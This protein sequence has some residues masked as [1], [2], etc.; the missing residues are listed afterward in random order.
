[1]RCLEGLAGRKQDNPHMRTAGLCD[2][3]MH[4]YYSDG[5]TSPEALV[6]HA[7]SLGLTAVALTDHDN[8]RGIPEAQVVADEL[9]IWLIPGVE[10]ASQWQGYGWSEWGYAVD[11]LG[12][13]VDRTLPEFQKLEGEMLA[14]YFDQF[15]EMV[16]EINRQGYPIMLEEI[17]Q[18]HPQ[19]PDV[20][21]VAS[22]LK[23]KGLTED[24]DTALWMAADCWNKICRLNFPVER[25]IR[26]IHAAGGVAVLAHP[27]VVLR[28]DG[29]WIE[30]EDLAKLVEMGLDG[31]EVYHYRLPDEKTRRHFLRLA[32]R[33]DLVV[34][35][36][37][38]EHGR[39][40]G[41][42]RM[43]TQPITE[44][45]ITALQARRRG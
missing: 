6:R 7:A 37:S 29:S 33:F 15:A 35:G 9:G 26:T 43:G 23:K 1:M 8:T 28:P 27:S 42:R 31:I 44:E 34:T 10:F 30:A 40:D 16:E 45:T 14:Y 39:P 5:C 20:F 22:V 3:H 12:Y 18:E 41:F 24:E 4:S 38:D 2:L 32:R 21:A 11:M 25:V 19:Y 36:G 13:F 17:R